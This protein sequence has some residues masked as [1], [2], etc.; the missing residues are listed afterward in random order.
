MT[1]CSPLQKSPRVLLLEG[2]ISGFCLLS[3]SLPIPWVLSFPP[4]TS[5]KSC[6][7]PCASVHGVGNSL[8]ILACT[9]M[10]EDHYLWP[11]NTRADGWSKNCS[12]L[13]QAKLNEDCCRIETSCLQGFPCTVL[14]YLPLKYCVVA[15]IHQHPHC[16]RR[17]TQVASFNYISYSDG[18]VAMGQVLVTIG[19]P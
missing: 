5:L 13:N 18:Q 8:P 3:I 16:K 11:L 10:T 19:S 14:S 7:W 2:G 1:T 6:V 12:Q 17:H 9:K 4:S 15:D